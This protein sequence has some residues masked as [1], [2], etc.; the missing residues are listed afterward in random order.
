MDCISDKCKLFTLKFKKIYLVLINKKNRN[1]N[2][3]QIKFIIK[4]I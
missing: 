1:R 3:N 4:N 2:N